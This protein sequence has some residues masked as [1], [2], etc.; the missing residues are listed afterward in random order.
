MVVIIMSS[1]NYFICIFYVSSD[2][3]G[4]L[5]QSRNEEN[6][7]KLS[8]LSLILDCV[9]LCIFYNVSTILRLVN[10]FIYSGIQFSHILVKKQVYFYYFFPDLYIFIKYILIFSNGVSFQAQTNK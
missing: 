10:V 7:L 3:Y 6:L 2:N 4:V 1:I 5:A 8:R 9:N